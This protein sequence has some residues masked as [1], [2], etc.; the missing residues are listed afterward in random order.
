MKTINRLQYHVSLLLC[1]FSLALATRAF[2]GD[3]IPGVDVHLKNTKSGEVITVTTPADGSFA[4]LN[5][6]KGTYTLWVS[7]AQCVRAINTKGT[8]AVSRQT[9]PPTDHQFG[10]DFHD[11]DGVAIALGRDTDGNGG[12]DLDPAT[13]HAAGKRQL[14]K[15]FLITKEWSASSPGL[16]VTVTNNNGSNGIG[17]GRLIG[18]VTLIK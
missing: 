8:G 10:V 15:P 18:H 2:A 7:E 3:P 9:T 1:I 4:I 16:F 17:S 13:A 14:N 12:L 11:A 5:L 6:S